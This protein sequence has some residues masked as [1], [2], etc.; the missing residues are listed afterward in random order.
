MDL[1]GDFG[2]HENEAETE[3]IDVGWAPGSRTIQG[4]SLFFGHFACS[5]FHSR[6]L[7]ISKKIL[8]YGRGGMPLQF[9]LSH[10]QSCISTRKL[11]LQ[12]QQN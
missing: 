6:R 1:E 4:E 12:Q 5:F 9:K 11:Q 8:F 2:G 7:Q 3:A 10:V